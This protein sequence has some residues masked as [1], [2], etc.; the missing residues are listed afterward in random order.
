MKRIVTISKPCLNKDVKKSAAG[1][2]RQAV[3]ARARLPVRWATSPAKENN[4]K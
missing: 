1:N 3:K 2:A 4:I